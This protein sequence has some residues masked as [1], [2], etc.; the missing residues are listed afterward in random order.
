MSVAKNIK[1]DKEEMIKELFLIKGKS[2][3]EKRYQL[4]EL[5]RIHRVYGHPSMDKLKTLMKDSRIEDPE[6][7]KK[8]KKIQGEFNICNKY[9]KRESKLRTSFPKARNINEVLSVDLK[10]VSNL[11]HNQNDKRKILYMMNEFSKMTVALIV[12]LKDPE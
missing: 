3:Q 5:K 9:R 11:V 12:K 4:K 2:G 10:P 6:L 8:L 7:V 1:D